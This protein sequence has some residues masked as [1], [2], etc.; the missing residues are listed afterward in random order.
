[1]VKVRFGLSPE[2][3]ELIDEYFAAEFDDRWLDNELVQD[4]L[5][6][7][8]KVSV[9]SEGLLY[10]ELYGEILSEDFSTGTKCLLLL[11]FV[12]ENEYY[13]TCMGDN[14]GKWAWKIGQL[15]DIHLALTRIFDFWP[16]SCGDKTGL[17]VYC[18]NSGTILN[19]MTEYVNEFVTYK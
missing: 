8:D 9:S 13:G 1:M 6:D 7:I 17:N 4:I 5:K 19:S 18:E 10:N 11:M 14:C 3:I 2:T 16:L 15:H 12:P